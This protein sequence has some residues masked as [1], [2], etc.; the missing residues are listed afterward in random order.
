MKFLNLGLN[1]LLGTWGNESTYS[2]SWGGVCI[3]GFSAG[4]GGGERFYRGSLG[5]AFSFDVDQK[6][7]NC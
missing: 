6:N 2:V 7:A 4:G 1:C 3:S 5:R